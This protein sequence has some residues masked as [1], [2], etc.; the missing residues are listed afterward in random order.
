MAI[1]P[2][3]GPPNPYTPPQGGYPP[4]HGPY[5]VPSSANSSQVPLANFDHSPSYDAFRSYPNYLPLNRSFPHLFFFLS[6]VFLQPKVTIQKIVSTTASI[7][8]LLTPI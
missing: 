3:N 6:L 4:E 2:A 7:L 5:R 8:P 1:R